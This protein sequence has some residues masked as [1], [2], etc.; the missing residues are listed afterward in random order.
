M[1]TVKWGF[2]MAPIKE[3]TDYNNKKALFQTVNYV[4]EQPITHGIVIIDELSV[5]KGLFNRVIRQ[6]QWDW[7]TVNMYLDYP[8]LKVC[9]K[10]V[11]ALVGLRKSIVIGDTQGIEMHKNILKDLDYQQ[12]YKNYIGFSDASTENEYIYILSR[13]EER[14]L[15]KIGMTTRNVVKRCKEINSATGVVYPF[16]PRQVYKVI[17]AGKAEKLIHDALQE[18]RVRDDRE[19][20]IISY[21]EACSIIETV[22]SENK[23]F[24][25]EDTGK[26]IKDFPR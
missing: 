20:F 2:G 24:Y 1:K 15:L 19:F 17:D 9:K 18:H 23:L 14:E 10:I 11:N 6:D 13:R 3:T 21:G 26:H 12:Y 8:S 25:N 5:A 4:Y 22:L 16:S 7:F